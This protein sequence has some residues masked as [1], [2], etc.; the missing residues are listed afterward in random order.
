[1]AKLG[2]PCDVCGQP[3]RSYPIYGKT[4]H[5][6]N[7]KKFVE[8]EISEIQEKYDAF[9]KKRIESGC[10]I[11]DIDHVV[12]SVIEVLERMTSK[13]IEAIN[14]ITTNIKERW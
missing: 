8:Q 14:Y 3:I 4:C 12:L 6:C 2:D 5:S 13:D 11:S 10:D 7:Y 9:Y 1:M